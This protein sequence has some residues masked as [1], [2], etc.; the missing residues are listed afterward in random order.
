LQYRLKRHYQNEHHKFTENQAFAGRNWVLVCVIGVTVGCI[1]SFVLV[2]THQLFEW[3]FGVVHGLIDKGNWGAA[4]MAYLSFS[5]FFVGVA[6][7]MGYIEPA[8]TGSGISEVKVYLN[9]VN[10]V[11]FLKPRAV[12][13]KAIGICFSV[14]SGLP[15]GKKAPMVHV[16]AAVAATV[17]QGRKKTFGYDTSWSVHTDFQNDKM[18]TDSLTYGIAAGI[19]AVFRAPIGGVLFALEE[20]ASH[21]SAT[22]TIKAFICAMISMLTVNILFADSG[23]GT[24]E[25]EHLFVFGQFKDVTEGETNYR[26][27]ELFVFILMGL[28]GGVIGA[29]FNGIMKKTHLRHSNPSYKKWQYVRVLCFTIM[30]AIISFC[31]PLVWAQCHTLPSE[32]DQVCVCV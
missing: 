13:A 6:L 12:I 25:I 8:S 5:L 3:K 18:I 20:S 4:F 9:G 26:T 16:G 30:M 19:A 23:F 10:L 21:W 29:G 32:E 1:G 28:S 14:S 22:V 7:I 15:I 24:T 27:W 11:D 2:L 31:L 17:S